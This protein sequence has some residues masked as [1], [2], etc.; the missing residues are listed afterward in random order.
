MANG[1]YNSSTPAIPG[2]GAD[3]FGDK[4]VGNQ[5]VDGTAQFTL[6]NFSIFSN[7]TSKDS[8][9]FS[10]GN[11]SAP[12]TLDTL[13]VEDIQQ[14]KLY[15]SNSLEV[16]INFDRSKVTN[17]TLYGS[18]RERIK[19]AVQNVIKKF[20]AAML[21]DS[22]RTWSD[23]KT[24][25]TAV[26]IT[27]SPPDNQTFLDLNL[28]TLYNPFSLEFTKVVSLFTSSDTIELRNLA[29]SYKKYALFY[30]GNEYPL[31]YIKPTSGN[32]DTGVLT[33]AIDGKPFDTSTF[34]SQSFYI[35]P[36]TLETEKAFDKLEDMEK[37][38][39]ERKSTPKYTAKFQQPRETDGGKIIES[40][41][42]ITWPTTDFW[43][44]RIN[45]ELFESYLNS[46][47][48]IG[49][50]FDSYKTNL[51]SRFLTTAAFKEFDTIDRK[52]D[53]VLKI[54]GRSFDAIK[55]YIDGLAYMANVTYDGLDNIP[56]NLLKNFAQTL[57][58]STPSAI[59][60]KGFLESIFHRNPDTLYEGQVTNQT[61]SELDTELYRRL[62]VNTAYLFKSKGTRN[63]IEFM[64]RFIGAPEALIEFNEHVYV[65]G[66]PIN[67][68]Q[69]NERMLTISSG[70][71]TEE[72]PVRDA[73]FSVLSGTFPPIT[74]TGFYLWI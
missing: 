6:G 16:F 21:F 55:K 65:A 58:W 17:Y 73:Y 43:N 70:V 31:Q 32:T 28:Y 46:L 72:V 61:P 2:N 19:V 38:L 37:F 25:N 59:E 34:T 36:T 1:I 7:V 22:V 45:G 14:A 8:R 40:T 39:V 47:Y 44:I 52:V 10:L 66:Q 71:Y 41:T 12:I 62:L 69:F 68:K 48:D 50:T 26:N 13:Q 67:M 53:K 54:Y 20:P 9:D 64:L 5:F 24:G 27:Y 63:G 51:V 33:I 49:D 11:F 74:I 30:K 3:R 23:Y 57:G 18:L 42:S 56:D 15:A 29:L 35:K 60:D 4:L